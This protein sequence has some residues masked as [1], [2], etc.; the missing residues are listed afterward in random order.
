MKKLVILLFCSIFLLN[1]CQKPAGQFD[2]SRG[3]RIDS[4]I[5]S[6]DILTYEVLTPDP[7]GWY[8]VWNRSDGVLVSVGLDSITWGNPLYLQSGWKYTFVAPSRPFQALLSAFSKSYS[9][10]ITA[11]LYKNGALIKTGATDGIPGFAK[12]M[13]DVQTD[14]WKGTVTDPVLTYEV[15]V[16]DPNPDTTVF[17]RDAWQ[18]QW[19]TPSGVVN[20]LNDRMAGS[21]F[22]MPGGWK[23][24]F[25]P[26]HLPFRMYMAAGPYSSGGGRVTINFYVNGNLVKTISSR[27]WMYGNEYWVQ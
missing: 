27:Q 17:Q 14:D 12:F 5:Q 13:V 20:D 23:Y 9:T 19:N 26:E 21:T 11:N 10:A 1:A 15:L 25:K 18:G 16:T 24:S 22:P 6:G 8:G 7:G 2:Q 3:D 4:V